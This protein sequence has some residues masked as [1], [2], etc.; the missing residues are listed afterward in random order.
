VKIIG[1]QFLDF[2]DFFSNNLLM[3]IVALITSIFVGFFIKPKTII[4][5]VELSEKFKFKRLFKVVIRYIAPICIV[6][7]LASSILSAFGL[8]SI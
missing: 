2:F 6:T 7:I 8:L 1:M 4:D 3:P 5:E